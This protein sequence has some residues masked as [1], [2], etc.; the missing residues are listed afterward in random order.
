MMMAE[1]TKQDPWLLTPTPGTSNYTMY[2][3]DQAQPPEPVCQVGSTTLKYQFRAIEDLYAWL[4][5][6]GDWVLLG[7]A[8][9]NKTTAPGTVEAWGR[10]PQNPVGEWYGLRKGY[11][12][13]FAMS[14]P[15]L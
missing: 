10:S 4:V 3:D 5:E 9:E 11:C 12:G 1:G 2:Q 7:A 15:P 6:Q 13:R 8:D 14:P